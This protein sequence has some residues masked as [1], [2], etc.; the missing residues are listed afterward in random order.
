[1]SPHLAIFA[2][3]RSYN[4]WVASETL[5]DY[6]LRYTADSARRWSIGRV[7]QTAIGATAFLA[8]E[9]LG[10][11]ITLSFGFADSV[12]AILL[13]CTIMF[14]VSLPIAVHAAREG[15]D[16]DLLTRGAGFGYL[17]STITSLI[18]ASFT[19]LLFAIEASIMALALVALT[20]MPLALA[21]L[22][23][24]L[25]VIP[26]AI[27]GMKA[28][29]RF[30]AFTQPLWIAVQF[31]PVILVLALE[32]QILGTWL[33]FTGRQ[34]EAA[35]GYNLVSIGLATSTLL[36]LLPQIGEQVDY[37]RF[38]PRKQSNPRRWWAAVLLAGPGW[39][40]IGAVKLLIGSCLAAYVMS[41]GLGEGAATDPTAMFLALFGALG[42]EGGAVLALVVAFVIACQ[43]KINVTNAYAGSI[44]WS[45]VFARLTHNHPGRVVWLVF[46]VLLALLLLLSGTVAVLHVVLSV[47]A[48]FTAGWMGALAADLTVSKPLGLSPASLEFRRGY[49]YDI[50]PVG[51]GGMGLSIAASCIATTGVLGAL[52]QAF[53]PV[54]GLCVAFVAT[55]ALAL[56]T[57][58]SYYIARAPDE[59]ERD[60]S[61]TCT[62]CENAF[63]RRDMVACPLLPGM[64]CSLCCTLETRCHDVCKTDSRLG[65]Q[66]DLVARQLLPRWGA[67]F[68]SS[69][70]GRFLAL[71]LVLCA[72][73]GGVLAT[74]ASVYGPAAPGAL[75]APL[76]AAFVAFAVLAG[77]A[78]WFITLARDSRRA[79]ERENR[80]QFG[81]LEEEIAAHEITDAELQRAK[82]VAESASEAKSRYLTSVSHE[83]R[84]P[85]NSIYGYAQLLER[86]ASVQP[87]EAGRIIRRSSEHLVNLVDGLLDISQVECGILRLSRDT[88]RLP[89]LVEQVANMFMPQA[90]AK[91]LA[92]TSRFQPDLPQFVSG[93]RKRLRQ[94]LINLVSNAVKFTE[95]GGVIFSVSY[96]SE[97]A[98]F[99]ITD[100]GIGIDHEDLECIF[101]PF[102]RGHDPEAQRQQGLGLGLA[103]T[104]SLV[105]ILGGELQVRSEKHRGTTFTVR[106]MLARTG[107]EGAL[108]L[109]VT[110]PDGYRGER[111]RIMVVDDS[112]AQLHVMT[113][114]LEPLGFAVRTFA[115][116]APALA[117]AD[118]ESFDLA[119]LDIRLPDLHG[120]ELAAML[121][122]KLGA[123]LGIVMISADAHEFE[124]FRGADAPHDAALGKPADLAQ[125]LA[126]IARLLEVEWQLPTSEP[127]GVSAAPRLRPEGEARALLRNILHASEIGHYREV[128]AHLA[129]LEERAPPGT[130]L[131]TILRTHLDAFNFEDV[132]RIVRNELQDV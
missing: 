32:P 18:Y 76:V 129:R 125:L 6:A 117:A 38:L 96:R 8:C 12:A 29:S 11:L 132:S 128:E 30:Q 27:F 97:I 28:I 15:L 92:F 9:A 108:P 123:K 16:L 119:L 34:G 17:G 70:A 114:L 51:V 60:E 5:E 40:I 63:Q 14:A 87:H 80:A 89:V 120:M 39:T 72:L 46:N 110:L 86:G 99:A 118:R 36:S 130:R 7:A 47:F 111:R 26:I 58:G 44:A 75:R 42:L 131:P 77:I 22:V 61:A 65:E 52:A 57:R 105:Q 49:L 3:R 85:L 126:I 102:D 21:H 122:R 35:G 81:K 13:A 1:M 10:A 50:N 20:G 101:Q 41:L 33:G 23:S 104:N 94:I 107:S 69:S 25:V 79:A 56:W 53:A 95:R 91:G 55:P 116:A 67:N 62:I 82:R 73:V 59:R 93:D 24:A 64:I 37:L 19:F 71:W 43:M 112:E 83:I 103:I 115:A 48:I 78:A 74:I 2:E 84:S 45:N 66:V 109:H 90:E 106:L 31:A 124:R 121:R 88:I 113:Q 127:P 98:T 100:T 4:K 54:L 68:V